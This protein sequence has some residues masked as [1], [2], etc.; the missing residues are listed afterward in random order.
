MPSVYDQQTNL[1]ARGK[2]APSVNYYATVRQPNAV[3]PR[4]E[5]VKAD[6]IKIDFT[7]LG[8]AVTNVANAKAKTDITIAELDYKERLKQQETAD[9]QLK[10]GVENAYASEI[11]QIQ[12]GQLQ[13]VYDERTAGRMLREINDKYLSTGLIEAGKMGTLAGHYAPYTVKAEGDT[14]QKQKDF[15]WEQDNKTANSAVEALPYLAN[16]PRSEQVAA[17]NFLANKSAEIAAAINFGNKFNTPTTQALAQNAVEDGAILNLDTQIL[18]TF[19]SSDKPLTKSEFMSGSIENLKNYLNSQDTTPEMKNAVYNRLLPEIKKQAELVGNITES[20]AK[21]LKNKLSI[22]ETQ[23]KLLARMLENPVRRV[24]STSGVW[25]NPTPTQIKEVE[26]ATGKPAAF[27]DISADPS[28][29]EYKFERDL[30]NGDSTTITAPRALKAGTY[31]IPL[32]REQAQYYV[33]NPNEYI[34]QLFSDNLPVGNV[35]ATNATTAVATIANSSS[36]RVPAGANVSQEDRAVISRN[37]IDFINAAESAQ[38]QSNVAKASPASQEAF[39]DCLTCVK[40]NNYLIERATEDPSWDGKLASLQTPLLNHQDRLV[41]RPN[42]EISVIDRKGVLNNLVELFTNKK[43]KD[44]V[45][46]FNSFL[47][48]VPEE[49][50]YNL[51]KD[52]LRG[53]RDSANGDV[54]GTTPTVGE[55]AVSNVAQASKD[56]YKWGVNGVRPEWIK[57][58]DVAY[59]G[60]LTGALKGSVKGGIPGAMVGAA[61]GFTKGLATEAVADQ[62]VYNVVEKVEGM[63]ELAGA[64]G[65]QKGEEFGNYIAQDYQNFLAANNLQDS[66]DSQAA[67]IKTAANNIIEAVADRA[68]KV[69][70]RGIELYDGYTR[71]RALANSTA[72]G[73]ESALPTP[74]QTYTD[75]EMAEAMMETVGKTIPN[76]A[77]PGEGPVISTDNGETVSTVLTAT[78]G[79]DGDTYAVKTV[80]PKTGNVIDPVEATQRPDMVIAKVPGEG[81][82]SVKEAEKKAAEFRNKDIAARGIEADL[83][84]Q[85]LENITTAFTVVNDKVRAKIKDTVTPS[86]EAIDIVNEELNDL[87]SKVKDEAKEDI[88]LIKTLWKMS[89][90]SYFDFAEGYNKIGREYGGIAQLSAALPAIAVQTGIEGIAKPIIAALEWL[91]SVKGEL[92]TEKEFNKWKKDKGSKK[93]RID[94]DPD[95]EVVSEGIFE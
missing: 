55:K 52:L 60:G 87:A 53:V 94:Y 21:Y 15:E 48:D 5:K 56:L 91:D 10:I 46:A 41:R 69:F 35:I 61:K 49:Q 47:A 71:R 16:R 77:T 17:G 26:R 39:K 66:E 58:G 33:E 13:G 86:K 37:Q 20:E 82:S 90:G 11:Q 40:G 78:V 19:T 59:F 42:G 32:T 45:N 1:N 93:I 76:L 28:A 3:E 29:G 89:T 57:E 75:Y 24:A 27:I 72:P 63:M 88:E 81:Q 6:P 85:A 62:G 67:Y 9:K 30:G 18:N 36:M 25:I 92:P 70:N 73:L 22:G 51:T 43:L 14:A 44:D 80:D 54:Y 2:Y 34:N 8:N 38:A 64:K 4:L 79:V 23:D 84:Q 95:I 83:N 50:K 7:S 12:A 65:I 68:D 74:Q 31:Q